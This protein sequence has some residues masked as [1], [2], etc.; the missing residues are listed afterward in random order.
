MK[1]ILYIVVG[2][3]TFSLG[4]LGIFLPILPT[5]IFYLLTTFLWLRSSTRL[6]QKLV[7][8]KSYQRYVEESLLQKKMTTSGMLRLFIFLFLIFVTP[9]VLVDNSLMRMSLALVYCAHVIG[10][11]W[12]LKV[13]KAT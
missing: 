13:K 2:F 10:L 9:A 5:T 11:T 12:Y 6:H 4:T 3:L 7:Q 8:S 1:K